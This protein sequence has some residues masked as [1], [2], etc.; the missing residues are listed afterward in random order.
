[1]TESEG[2]EVT[3]F[4]SDDNDDDIS[5]NDISDDDDNYE[6]LGVLLMIDESS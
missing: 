3:R 2:R 5:D 1:M 6:L 4:C